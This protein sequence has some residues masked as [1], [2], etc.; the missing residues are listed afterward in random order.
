MRTLNPLIGIFL[1]AVQQTAS[2]SLIGDTVTGYAAT[3]IPSISYE[4]IHFDTSAVVGSGEEFSGLE[5]IGSSGLTLQYYADIDASSITIGVRHLTTTGI[6]LSPNLLQ[7]VFGSI[8][9]PGP[10]PIA[11][12]ELDAAFTQE[13]WPNPGDPNAKWVGWG[14]DTPTPPVWNPVWDDGNKEL[15]IDATGGFTIPPGYDVWARFNIVS[16]VPLPPALWLFT[17]GVLGLI[18]LARRRQAV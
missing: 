8:D 6:V 17:C 15:I 4:K 9:W 11:G 3:L 16:Q 18:G 2:A 10:A 13:L 12:V 7:F 14:F 5:S 1:L